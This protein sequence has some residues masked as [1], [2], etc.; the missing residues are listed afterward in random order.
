MLPA[1]LEATA[2]AAAAVT[3]GLAGYGDTR[4]LALRAG[5]VLPVL[6]T[7]AEATDVTA[8]EATDEGD[9]DEL[10]RCPFSADEVDAAS[11]TDVLR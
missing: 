11:V 6:E 4:G 3:V 2:A 7:G 8:A 9:D 5:R 1:L 10:T